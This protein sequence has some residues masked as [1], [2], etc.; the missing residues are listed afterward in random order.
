MGTGEPLVDFFLYNSMESSSFLL[1]SAWSLYSIMMILESSYLPC[2][3]LHDITLKSSWLTDLGRGLLGPVLVR[4]PPLDP[5]C[6]GR[7]GYPWW[8]GEGWLTMKG[9]WVCKTQLVTLMPSGWHRQ[10]RA[11]LSDSRPAFCHWL[12]GLGGLPILSCSKGE[13]HL[14]EKGADGPALV[15]YD[16]KGHGWQI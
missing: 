1:S 2:L 14:K 6:D 7:W 12:E 9:V 4:R 8:H 11:W 10:V 15:K 5:G 13:W 3:S 16:P